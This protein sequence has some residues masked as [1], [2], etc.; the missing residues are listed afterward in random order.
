MIGIGGFGTREELQLGDVSEVVQRLC[1]RNGEFLPQRRKGAKEDLRIFFA[2][3]LL[4]GRNSFMSRG[5]RDLPY[6]PAKRREQRRKQFVYLRLLSRPKLST[7]WLLRRSLD[8]ERLKHPRK[9]RF[10]VRPIRG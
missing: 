9:I 4:C 10:Q 8:I 6:S 5:S 3:L 7:N 1:V 2:P